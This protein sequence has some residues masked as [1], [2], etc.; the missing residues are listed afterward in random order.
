MTIA[1]WL[2]GNDSDHKSV[3]EV[4]EIVTSDAD[5]DVASAAAAATC[6]ASSEIERV[7]DRPLRWLDASS[8]SQFTLRKLKAG[9]SIVLYGSIEHS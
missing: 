6:L 8:G 7:A 5:S 2:T 9:R 3:I 4:A 1:E